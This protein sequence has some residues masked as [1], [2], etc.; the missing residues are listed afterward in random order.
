MIRW[1]W[2]LLAALA[3]LGWAHMNRYTSIEIDG[4]IYKAWDRWEHRVCLFT[5]N[6]KHTLCFGPGQLGSTIKNR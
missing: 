2:L 1:A 3:L 6:S 5:Y 4:R